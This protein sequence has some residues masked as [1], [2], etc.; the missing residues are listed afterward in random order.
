[1]DGEDAK[2]EVDE[3]DD[4]VDRYAESAAEPE[5]LELEDDREDISIDMEDA[6]DDDGDD[7]DD[8]GDDDEETRDVG[9]PCRSWSRHLLARESSFFALCQKLRRSSASHCTSSWMASSREATRGMAEKLQRAPIVSP[10]FTV[11]KALVWA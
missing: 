10:T 2:D 5:S 3:V 9:G 11:F 4:E 8:N 7:D 6:D 1:M